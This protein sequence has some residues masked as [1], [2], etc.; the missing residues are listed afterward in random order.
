MNDI[1]N[2]DMTCN[3]GDFLNLYVKEENDIEE[4][5]V[6]VDEYIEEIAIPAPVSKL[7]TFEEASLD[8]MLPFLILSD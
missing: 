3:F 7:F 6:L 4:H 2:I 8:R 5:T 1:M